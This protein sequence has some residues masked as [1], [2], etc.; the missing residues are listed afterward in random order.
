MESIHVMGMKKIVKQEESELRAKDAEHVENK[1]WDT[2][3][4]WPV[5]PDSFMRE[6]CTLIERGFLLPSEEKKKKK[7][8]RK[9]LE[10]ESVNEINKERKN[11]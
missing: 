1:E 9:N 10:I 6:R 3:L 5:L 7:E 8:K 2:F 4:R 11:K